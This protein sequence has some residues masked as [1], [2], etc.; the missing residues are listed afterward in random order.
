MVMLGVAPNL[1]LVAPECFAELPDAPTTTTTESPDDEP[2]PDAAPTVPDTLPETTTTA[3]TASVVA[4]VDCSGANEGRV[5]AS[6]CLNDD[7]DAPGNLTAGACPGDPELDYPGDRT[8]RR[9]AARVCLQR[10]E[11][12]FGEPYSLSDRVAEEFVPNE[13]LWNRGD[14]RVVCHESDGGTG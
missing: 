2:D 9:A 14:R 6:F 4:V 7:E 12:T 3:P 5:Y 11:E 13:G 8:I 1:D 10:F